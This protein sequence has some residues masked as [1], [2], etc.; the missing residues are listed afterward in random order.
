MLGTETMGRITSQV[1]AGV[2][3]PSDEPAEER[4]YR[5]RT[6]QWLAR[7]RRDAEQRGLNL[8]VEIPSD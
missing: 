4:E 8:V 2:K 3:P 6:E 1:V 5:E 7:M